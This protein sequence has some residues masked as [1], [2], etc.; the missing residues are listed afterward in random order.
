MAAQVN[1]ITRACGLMLLVASGSALSATMIQDM[2][3]R[4]SEQQMALLELKMLVFEATHKKTPGL[5]DSKD[6]TDLVEIIADHRR[7]LEEPEYGPEDVSQLMGICSR[8]SEAAIQ[9]LTLDLPQPEI[10][11]E[12]AAAYVERMNQRVIQN[13]HRHEAKFAVLDSFMLR[14]TAPIAGVLG[15]YAS[16][17]KPEEVTAQDKLQGKIA[18]KAVMG[19]LENAIRTLSAIDGDFPLIHAAVLEAFE[20]NSASFASALDLDQRDAILEQIRSAAP[21]LQQ[22]QRDALERTSA[23]FVD[24][25]CEGMCRF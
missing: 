10:G 12:R 19:Q 13:R 11:Q 17:Q 14:C 4:E 9:L 24:R 18:R 5:L 15:R 20:A 2:S 6:A 1:L 21:R 23:A 22:E 7:L 25:R 8:A 16:D 3:A